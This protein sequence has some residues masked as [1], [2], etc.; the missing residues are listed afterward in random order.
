VEDPGSLGAREQ[1]RAWGVDTP[2]VPVDDAG[3]V[4]KEL[5]GSGARVVLVT[6]AHQFPTGVVL[7]G[8][9]G[10]GQPSRLFWPQLW[11]LLAA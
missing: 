4:V 8:S 10:S 3:L 11:S 7:S 9:I 1:L 6:P 2:P 5:R